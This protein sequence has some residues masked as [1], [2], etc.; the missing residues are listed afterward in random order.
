MQ[1]GELGGWALEPDARPLA[2]GP[3]R[4]DTRIEV[5][6]PPERRGARGELPLPLAA[7]QARDRCKALSTM[8][9]GHADP[10]LFALADAVQNL[11]QGCVS[12][13][14][15]SFMSWKESIGAVTNISLRAWTFSRL[16]IAVQCSQLM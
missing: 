12:E 4:A 7:S 6:A 15:M 1:T 13:G 2:L 3:T 10:A 14:Q 9:G 8:G 16:P 11:P 5:R